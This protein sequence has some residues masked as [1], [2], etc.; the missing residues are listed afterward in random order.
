MV[1]TNCGWTPDQAEKPVAA[2][3]PSNPF[4]VEEPIW[5]PEDFESLAR[6][7]KA[8]RRAD[9]DGRERHRARAISAR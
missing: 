5:P 8:D 3:K 1:D 2:M 7:R 6:L 4:W 9:G